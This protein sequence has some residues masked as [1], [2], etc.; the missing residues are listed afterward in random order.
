MRKDDQVVESES[1]A[2]HVRKIEEEPEPPLLQG[3]RKAR[4]DRRK[5]DEKT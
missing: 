3:K 2:Y 5:S 4:G 1:P